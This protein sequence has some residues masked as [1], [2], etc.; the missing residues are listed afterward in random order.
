M[1][2]QTPNIQVSPVTTDAQKEMF[3]DVPFKVYRNN[4]NWIPPITSSIAKQ[5]AAENNPFL[6]YGEFQQFIAVSQKNSEPL[7]RIV[8]IV[9]RRLIESEGKNVG[10]FG[11]FECVEDFDVA[12]SLLETASKWL[13]DKGMNFV[14]G[15]INLSTHNSCLFL[16]DS[17]DV[18]PIMMTPYN[19]PYYPEFMEK[20]G[21]YK[22]NDAYVYN[23]PLDKPLDPKFEKA[24]R[25]ACKSGVTF[26]PLRTKGEE[27]EQDC[28]DIYNLVGQVF[29]K[30]YSYSY[31]TVEE[32]VS[33][34]KDL[35][36]MAD[37]RCISHSRT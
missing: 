33:Q 36:D 3:L 26:R 17:F 34:A 16:V 22:G 31:R 6:E 27:F 30:N 21:Y 20:A 10:I 18:Q 37:P 12:N 25:I 4:P 15:P 14:R 13:R 11:Y 23:F 28:R 19:P 8:A 29:T 9:N 7:G 24:Y 35:Q 5:L 32:F 1:V 2:T